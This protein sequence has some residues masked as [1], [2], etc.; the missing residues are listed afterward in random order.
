MK[1]WLSKQCF[2]LGVLSVLLASAASTGH[3]Q[4][5]DQIYLLSNPGESIKGLIDAVSASDVTVR[6]NGVPRKLPA[7]DVQRIQFAD[8]PTELLQAAAMFRKGQLKD[9]R[10]ELGNLNL[11]EVNNKW[12]QQDVAYMLAFIETRSALAGDGDKNSAGTLLVAFL[13]NHSDSYHYF[14]AVELFG[15]LAYV[16]GSFDMAAQQYTILSKSPWPGLQVRGTLRL[17][18]STVGKGDYAAAL[19]MFEK[20]A[21][22]SATTP[23]LQLTVSEARAGQARCLGETG[24]P[25]EGIALANVL[26]KDNDPKTQKPLFAQAYNAQGICYRSSQKPKDAILAFLHTHLIFN[27]SPD[28]H[29]EALFHLSQLWDEVNKADRAQDTKRLLREK[30]AGT[31]W[32]QKSRSE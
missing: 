8:S 5:N 6:V 17:A 32:E 21:G 25:A 1:R 29:A 14:E 3:A 24:K 20:V 4:V 19:G 11:A 22:I 15:D 9:A 13:K 31:Y 2:S 26:I 7:N 28:A 23:E 10:T 30:Y 27:E 16:V 12:I 18:N